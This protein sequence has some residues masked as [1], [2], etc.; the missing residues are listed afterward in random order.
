[1]F[2]EPRYI[3]QNFNKFSSMVSM[4]SSYIKLFPFACLCNLLNLLRMDG[5][6]AKLGIMY[7]AQSN[8]KNLINWPVNSLKAGD[9]SPDL[10]SIYQNGAGAFYIH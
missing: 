9:Y 5:Q 10:K 2:I 7:E 3:E 8:L 6:A 4:L 1:M